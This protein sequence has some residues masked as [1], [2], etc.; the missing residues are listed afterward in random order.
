[1]AQ[2]CS[3]NS[4]SLYVQEIESVTTIFPH[5]RFK[6]TLHNSS[7]CLAASYFRWKNVI[8]KC[9]VLCER[10]IVDILSHQQFSKLVNHSSKSVVGFNSSLMA[11]GLGTGSWREGGELPFCSRVKK[12][13]KSFLTASTVP[14]EFILG[15]MY[16]ADYL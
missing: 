6:P 15:S 7:K 1:M 9:N 11:I 4:K 12:E 5:I 2:T 13:W 16:F 10:A 14:S 3:L 8:V